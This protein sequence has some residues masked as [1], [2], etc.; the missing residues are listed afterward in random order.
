MRSFKESTEKEHQARVNNQNIKG[1]FSSI[2]S[3]VR[4]F[5]NQ[6]IVRMF[7]LFFLSLKML[8]IAHR[9]NLTFLPFKDAFQLGGQPTRPTFSKKTE[10]KP[11][12]CCNTFETDCLFFFN[13]STFW[14]RGTAV[15]Q[16]GR[17]RRVCLP[18]WDSI[19]MIFLFSPRIK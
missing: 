12:R 1:S 17:S 6:T 13:S 3:S 19:I 8:A 15:S 9:E 16:S 10:A 7:H 18:S 5:V 2:E 14:V 4:L 11:D